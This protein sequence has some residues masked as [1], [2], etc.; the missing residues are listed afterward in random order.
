MLRMCLNW[1]VLAGLALVAVGV[2]VY[3]PD[4]LGA[5]VP[6]FLLAACPLSMLLMMRS[7]GHG[8]GGGGNPPAS[9]LSDDPGALRTGMNPLTAEQERVSEKASPA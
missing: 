8:A 4:L 3:L 1:K 7:M 9:P 2:G 5:A 6:I